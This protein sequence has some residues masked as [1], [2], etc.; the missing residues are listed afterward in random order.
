[1]LRGEVRLETV[2]SDPAVARVEF[3][4]DGRRAATAD[5]APFAAALDLGPLPF[6]RRGAAIAD[7]AGGAEG[8]RDELVLNEGGRG[9]AVQIEG[10][11]EPDRSG[12]VD[13]TVSVS[14]PEGDRLDRVELWLNQRRVATLFSP[15]WRYRLPVGRGAAGGYV[16][17]TA[18]LADGST[19]EDVRFL[20]GSGHGSRIEVNLVE[21]YVVVS[22]RDGRPV[23]DLVQ[24]DF[25]VFED[26]GRRELAGFGDAGELPVTVGL[27][28]DSSASMFFKLPKVQAAATRFLDGLQPGRD[29]AFLVDFDTLPR[30]AAEP[31]ADL[32]RVADAVGGLD[33]G[34]QTSLWEAIVYSLVQLQGVHGRKALVVYS[35]GA[36]EDKGFRY[37]TCLRFARKLGIP[38]YVIVSNNEAVRTDWLGIRSF[39]DRVSRLTDSVGGRTYLVRT[40]QDL[41]AVYRE[42]EDELRSQYLLTF[43]SQRDTEATGWREVRVDVHGRGLTARTVSGHE[44]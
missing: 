17:A 18:V 12:A 2:V 41:G 34:G 5:R 15:P 23:R 32:A 21:L 10:P 42:I 1:M 36:D 6:R 33:A 44:L 13:V 7:D 31:T 38:I 26:G 20:D 22:D 40:G 11:L 14:H 4:L 19:A 43:Y 30:L 9:F 35:D 37:R 3:R 16:R 39:G 27:A 28:I 8:G 25:E 24:G 29:H